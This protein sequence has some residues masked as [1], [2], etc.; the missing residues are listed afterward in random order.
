M[1]IAPEK[2]LLAVYYVF[3]LELCKDVLAGF[4]FIESELL[5]RTISQSKSSYAVNIF[6]NLL[7][8]IPKLNISYKKL[9]HCR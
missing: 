1:Q 8:S 5:E 2:F 9:K 6:M 4:L 3:D 7:H